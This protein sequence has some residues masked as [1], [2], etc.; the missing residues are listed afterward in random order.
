M[1]RGL[2]KLV[3]KY[4]RYGSVEMYRSLFMAAQVKQLQKYIPEIRPED[5][6]RCYT[7]SHMT[8]T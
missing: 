7:L 1:S 2:R 4:W 6:S 5:I 8:L 3:M